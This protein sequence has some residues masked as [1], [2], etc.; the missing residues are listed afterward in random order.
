MQAGMAR[1]GRSNI[2]KQYVRAVWTED[3]PGVA[4]DSGVVATSSAK[5]VDVETS[6]AMFMQ[7]SGELDPILDLYDETKALGDYKL[8]LLSHGSP[9]PLS[10]SGSPENCGLTWP[11]GWAKVHSLPGFSA[12]PRKMPRPRTPSGL[13]GPAYA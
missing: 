13:D 4:I 2:T 3:R 11:R 6:V 9:W 10:F 12:H 5:S 8:H 7:D 1:S